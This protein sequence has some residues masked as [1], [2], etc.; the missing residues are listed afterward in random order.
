MTFNRNTFHK[1]ALPEVGTYRSPATTD[2]IL[3]CLGLLKPSPSPFP[4]LRLGGKKDGAYLL[5]EDFSGVTACFSPGVNNTKPFEDEL[6][7]R[8][9]IKCHLCDASSEESQF[10]TPLK[11]RMQTFLK[12]WLDI[13]GAV[14]SISLEEWVDGLSETGESPDLLLQIDIE[15]A[16]YRNLLHTSADVLDRFRIIVVEYHDLSALKDA[17]VL[18]TVLRPTFEKMARMFTP[19]H[20][21]PNNCCG[22]FSIP[23]TS[24]RI[25][26]VLEVTYLHKSRFSGRPPSEMHRVLCPHPLDIVNFPQWPA[27][28]LGKEWLFGR[29]P[30]RS[31]VKIAVD[32][33]FSPLCFKLDH[34]L[35]QLTIRLALRTRGREVMRKIG[36]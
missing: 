34:L 9:G 29:R 23:R 19:V 2:N 35:S 15:G 33:Y 18:E 20:V 32:K 24:V 1:I 7:E 16:E 22:D 30:W 17:Q 5:P 27:I 6:V 14:N 3:S 10:A 4:L 8:F 25:P 12:K 21:H 36:W 11:P 13:G 28:H 26:E 31:H